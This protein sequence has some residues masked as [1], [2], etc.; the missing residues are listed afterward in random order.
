MQSESRWRFP[1]QSEDWFL[2]DT[3]FGAHAH[4]YKFP[5]VVL[6]ANPIP[7]KK[8]PVN[9]SPGEKTAPGIPRTVLLRAEVNQPGIDGLP[10]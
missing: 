1:H 6:P 3:L 4:L 5:F 2:N 9:E 7:I 8:H 10:L